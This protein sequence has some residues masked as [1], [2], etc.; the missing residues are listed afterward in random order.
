[1]ADLSKKLQDTLNK[2]N[3][4]YGVGTISTLLD[5]PTAR[6]EVVSTGSLTLDIALGVGGLPLG[7]IVEALGWESSGKTTIAIHTVVEAQKMGKLCA[8]IDAEH[9]FDPEYFQALGG[10][11]DKLWFV[12]PDN[13]EQ[14]FEIVEMLLDTAEFSVIVVDSVAALIP[15]AEMDGNMGDSKM[16]LHARLMSQ[17]MRKLAGKVNK[18]KCILLMI[19]QLRHNIGV[20]YGSPDVTT[21]GNALK[22]YASVRLQVSKSVIT[23]EGQDTP[24]NRVKVKVIKNKVAPPFKLAEFDLMFG[25]GISKVG[26][27]LDLAVENNIVKKAGSWYSYNDSKLGQGRDMVKTVLQ[28]NPELCDELESKVR[29]VYL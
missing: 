7:R 17:A 14:A 29:E 26:E 16:G 5:K 27:I 12:Q 10:D 21:G 4:T 13:G 3:T 24:G 25:E 23:K 9:A 6:V 1:M 22:F 2:I 18:S 19:N 8:I 28:D 11:L 15:K 20:V